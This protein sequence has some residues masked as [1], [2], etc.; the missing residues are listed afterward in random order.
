MPGNQAGNAYALSGSTSATVV[1]TAD[2][3]EFGF[4]VLDV[5]PGGFTANLY[6]LSGLPHGRCVIQLALRNLACTS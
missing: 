3:S 1:G 4:A 2:L 6:D 5:V